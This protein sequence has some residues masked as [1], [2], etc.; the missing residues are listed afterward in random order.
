MINQK[1]KLQK[2]PQKKEKSS[3]KHKKTKFD[4]F[5]KS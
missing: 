4:L 1:D 3:T 2:T 5:E